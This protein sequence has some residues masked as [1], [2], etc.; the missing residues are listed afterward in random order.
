MSTERH[1]CPPNATAGTLKA[2]QAS[3]C[4]IL[5]TGLSLDDLEPSILLAHEFI[6]QGVLPERLAFALCRV[7]E[8]E[9]E[10]AE[11]RHYIQ[12]AGYTVLKGA[13]PEKIAYR[14]ASDEGR[15]LTETR[16]PSLNERSDTVAQSVI[17]YLKH[18]YEHSEE[19]QDG[20]SSTTQ[21]S[22]SKKR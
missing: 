10:I 8:S 16:F 1:D 21:R 5:P 3:T 20:Q 13:I 19:T 6:K 12:R 22:R 14:R 18:V 7:G 2:A 9:I 17:D 11:A 4:L 15:T